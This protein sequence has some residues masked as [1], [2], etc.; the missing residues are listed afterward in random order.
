MAM[1]V[2]KT[3][4]PLYEVEEFTRMLAAWDI[5]LHM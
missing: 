5:L 1:F 4:G 3:C 2:A